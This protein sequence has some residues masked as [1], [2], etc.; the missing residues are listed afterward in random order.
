MGLDDIYYLDLNLRNDWTSTL[1]P[2]KNSYLYGGL[3]ASVIAS[4]WIDVELAEL[5]EDRASAA[6]VG[7][8]M[9]PY[10]VFPIYYTE[11]K[12]GG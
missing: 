12:Y 2:D 5:L 8:T 7:S 11:T 10:L 4:N 3:S 6:Q 1:H 9:D